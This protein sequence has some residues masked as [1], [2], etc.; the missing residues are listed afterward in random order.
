MSGEDNNNI[1]TPMM[2]Q[3]MTMLNNRFNS[4]EE[5]NNNMN[6]N[7]NNNINSLKADMNNINEKVGSLQEENLA[8]REELLARIDTKSRFFSRASSRATSPKQLMKQLHE[9]LPVDELPLETPRG[10]YP[11]VQVSMTEIFRDAKAAD[12]FAEVNKGRERRERKPAI[13]QR[14]NT[15]SRRETFATINRPGN[16]V[17]KETFTR[18]TPEKKAHLSSPLTLEKYLTFEHDMLDFQQKYYVEVRYTNYVNTDLKY[19]I[20]ARF[21]LTDSDFYELSQQDLHRCLSEMIAPMTKSEFL[22]ML[23]R[24]VHFTLHHGYIPRSRTLEH[25]STSCSL[26]GKAY[27]RD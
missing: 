1:N 20:R 9:K 18:T 24:A 10:Q 27:T 14:D 21:G 16:P 2:E 6:I 19:E 15:I 8:T 3:L 13:Y 7:T 17:M 26:Q 23:K 12:D 5:N 4:I 25:F 11:D 22:S